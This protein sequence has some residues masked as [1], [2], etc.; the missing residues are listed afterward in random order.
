MQTR[1]SQFTKGFVFLGIPGARLTSKGY[2]DTKPVA[3][4]S[5]PQGRALNRR[6]ELA[7]P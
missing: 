6:V 4:N 2:A 1:S 3:Q 7:R 5:T